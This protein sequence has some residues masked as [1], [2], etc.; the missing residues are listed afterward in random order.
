MDTAI[1]KQALLEKIRNTI[2]D[3][4]D[5]DIS[6]L[7][8]AESYAQ[9]RQEIDLSERVSSD[10]S[11]HFNDFF[12][13]LFSS[14]NISNFCKLTCE[15]KI[16][17]GDMDIIHASGSESLLSIVKNELLKEKSKITTRSIFSLQPFK[18][19]GLDYNVFIIKSEA[20]GEE[21][22]LIALSS[23][24]YTQENIFKK[25]TS[26]INSYYRITAPS[27]SL[28]ADSI[29]DKVRA[30]TVNTIHQYIN[31]NVA[32]KA[33]LY[34]FDNIY[35]IFEHRGLKTLLDIDNKIVKSLQNYHG[36]EASVTIL[37]P[38]IYL[39][40]LPVENRE[41]VTKTRAPARLLFEYEDV[42]F[43]YWVY[44]QIID[45]KAG[46]ASIFYWISETLKE[47]HG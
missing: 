9:L 7:E 41:E 4:V 27:P 40:L 26:I 34:R 15:I 16:S 10:S 14:H 13:K 23:S 46:A 24:K 17:A 22:F 1:N 20:S 5:G 31:A 38:S 6:S 25:F 21:S 36:Y 33:M 3:F 18:L 30:D 43:R 12:K 39:V 8:A 47:A 37:G 28:G 32:V 44:R 29:Y 45:D 42:I 2:K 35:E 11:G 19:E